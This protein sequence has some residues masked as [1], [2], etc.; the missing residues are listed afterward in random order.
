MLC[1]ICCIVLL[2]LLFRNTFAYSSDSLTKGQK[3]A[4]GFIRHL[5]FIVAL[6]YFR[7][8]I[9]YSISVPLCTSPS[10]VCCIAEA[11][12]RHK[13]RPEQSE[14]YYSFDCVCNYQFKDKYFE[15]NTRPCARI[16]SCSL[17][18]MNGKKFLNNFIT[19]L[20]QRS[21]VY[22]IV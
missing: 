6:K 1:T 14:S 8:G 9:F 18:G 22:M 10:N 15:R 11:N 16:Y 13:S 20:S 17:C 2:I 21:M 19:E 5:K 7:V 4:I 3:I 12:I